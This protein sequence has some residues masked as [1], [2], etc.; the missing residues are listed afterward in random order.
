[1]L[2]LGIESSCDETAAAIYDGAR[3]LSNVVASQKDHIE[4]GGIVPELASR[5]HERVIWETVQQAL[6]DA[7]ADAGEIDA[8]AVTEGPGL[9][10][11]LLV[12]LCFA[13]G[14]SVQWNKPVIGVN[15]ID[16]HIYAAFIDA[17]PKLPAIALVVSGGH[18]QI[19][20]VPSPLNHLLMGNTRDDA[21]GEAFDKIG[22]MIGLPYPAGPAIDQLATHGNPGFYD[23]PRAMMKKGLDFSFSGLKTSVLYFLEKMKPEEKERVLSDHMNDLCASISAAITDV[24][25]YKL[26]RAIKQA[27]VK[28]VIIA[29]G[30]SANRMLRRKAAEMAEKQGVELHIPNPEYCTDNA[31]MIAVTGWFKAQQGL[32]DDERLKPYAR[33]Q[34]EKYQ[35]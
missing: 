7:G 11:S 32:Y 35:K 25:I 27:G 26:Q 9:M 29:G 23:F 28:S 1:M 8:I 33:H 30:V 17:K 15:H 18:T 13:K 12:G 21:A 16:A 31:A 20:H 10:G 19:F 6:D 3:L 22:K 4:F 2:I 24:L 5:A 34:W 14:L